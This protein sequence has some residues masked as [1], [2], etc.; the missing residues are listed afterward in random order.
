MFDIRRTLG[1]ILAKRF[2]L[3][4]ALVFSS[5]QPAFS[6]EEIMVS[7]AGPTVTFLPA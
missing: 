7:Y 1:S 4:L 6:L 3:H 5:V 2:C